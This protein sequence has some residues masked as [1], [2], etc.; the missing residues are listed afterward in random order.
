M[1]IFSIRKITDYGMLVPEDLLNVLGL[2]KGEYVIFK[3]SKTSK[4]ITIKPLLTPSSR[5]A[6]LKVLL[7][8]V[9]GTNANVDAV[10]GKLGI[11]IVFGKGGLVDEDMYS[12]AKVLDMSACSCTIREIKKEIEAIPEVIDVVIEEL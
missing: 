8:N 4:E 10:L 6:E 5:A 1:P 2:E 7:K 12:S 3:G 9:P 11:N